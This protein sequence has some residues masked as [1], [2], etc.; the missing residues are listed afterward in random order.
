MQ[1]IDGFN[2]SNM[3]S[4]R[5]IIR[6]FHETVAHE[7]QLL[8]ALYD[9][10]D[11]TNSASVLRDIDADK[12]ALCETDLRNEYGT[13][14]PV[15][16]LIK[17]SFGHMQTDP[18]SP[19]ARLVGQFAA[20]TLFPMAGAPQPR[21]KYQASLTKRLA[22]G[23]CDDAEKYFIATA[24]QLLRGQ[25]HGQNQIEVYYGTD[26]SVLAIKKSD[27]AASAIL[28]EPH[29]DD[30]INVPEGT[31]V[32]IGAMNILGSQIKHIGTQTL[33]AHQIAEPL[34]INPKRLSAWGQP[35]ECQSFYAISVEGSNFNYDHRF[36]AQIRSISLEH[37]RQAGNR[38][39]Q[40][41]AN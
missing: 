41:C 29:I 18:S 9:C 1:S 7:K 25:N 40:I 24:Y 12:K 31:I 20:E 11:V 39:L 8:E 30:G 15:T 33:I 14:T 34:T 27:N 17:R 3:S 6:R 38:V 5:S 10:S 26:N 36:A 2:T 37:F 19:H 21:S 28:L 35:E 16:Y 32:G 4:S 13:P 23:S 22:V